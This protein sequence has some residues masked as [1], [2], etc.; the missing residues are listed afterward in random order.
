[1][2]FKVTCDE[3]E[4]LGSMVHR[5]LESFSILSLARDLRK[6]TTTGTAFGIT[7]PS[8]RRCWICAVTGE[9]THAIPL[10]DESAH[11]IVV[12]LVVEA[13]QVSQDLGVRVLCPPFFQA[14]EDALADAV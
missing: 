3:D 9:V 5:T 1:L 14:E 6:V 13:R 10:L 4:L 8:G 2:S 12:A 7:P 11:E